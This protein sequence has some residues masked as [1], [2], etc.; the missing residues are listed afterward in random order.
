MGGTKNK[1]CFR[2]ESTALEGQPRPDQGKPPCR[3]DGMLQPPAVPGGKGDGRKV[4]PACPGSFIG[5]HHQVEN[6]SSERPKWESARTPSGLTWRGQSNCG[7][8]ERERF[9]A[10]LALSIK[11]TLVRAGLGSGCRPRAVAWSSVPATVHQA[12]C[13]ACSQLLV[14]EA[15]VHPCLVV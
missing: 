12:A 4:L 3:V 8:L 10:G 15:K 11:R 5:E 7:T 6:P 1:K 13:P 9:G 2:Q 14:V